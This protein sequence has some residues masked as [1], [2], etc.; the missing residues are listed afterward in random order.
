MKI[1]ATIALCR[2]PLWRDTVKAVLPLIDE[3]YVRFDVTKGDPDV[4]R[5]IKGLAGEK[6]KKV[7]M[8]EEPWRVPDW[9]EDMLRML[10]DAKPD[11]VLC[12]DEDEIFGD[13]IADEIKAFAI[14]DKDVMLFGYNP[15]VSREGRVI[16]G[17]KPYPCEPHAKAYRWKEGLSHYPYHWNGMIAQYLNP[18]C[19]W[20]AKTK[21]DHYCCFTP[22]LERLK[23]WPDGIP[24]RRGHKVVTMLGFGPSVRDEIVIRGEVWSINDAYQVF[25]GRREVLQRMTRIYEMHSEESRGFTPAKDG[26]PHFRHLDL[27]GQK[28]RRIFMQKPHPTVTN[29]E[30][31]P[32]HAIQ[33]M[34]QGVCPPLAYDFTGGPCYMVAHAIM[35]GYG[36]I[37]TYGFDQMDYAHIP[38]RESFG[39]WLMFAAG[40]GIK[41]SGVQPMWMQDEMYG[42]T[43]LYGYHYGPDMDEFWNRK[44]WAGHPMQVNYKIPSR[45]EVGRLAAEVGG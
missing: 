15:L 19:H 29:S 40:R 22:G 35:E 6:L 28:G 24:Y 2:F 23:I 18:A 45:S 1:V 34:V 5:E 41:I 21:I 8:V 38:Q 20:Q 4:V 44:I 27:E 12:L 26:V 36:E 10:D 3:L 33:E 9:R 30:A 16:N 7:V 43:R 11:I 13:G 32:L 42:G 39:R 17:G 14:S 37:R 31:Y 25:A